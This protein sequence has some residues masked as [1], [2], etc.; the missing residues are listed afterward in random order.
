MFFIAQINNPNYYKNNRKKVRR[1]TASW[2]YKGIREGKEKENS[3][4]IRSKESNERIG[5]IIGLAI[6]INLMN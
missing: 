2:R 3:Q 5:F 4:E 6:I 1:K